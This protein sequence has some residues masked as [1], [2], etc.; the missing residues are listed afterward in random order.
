[1]IT[2]FHRN[3]K[4]KTR[5][6]KPIWIYGSKI[7][8]VFMRNVSLWEELASKPAGNE[9]VL[10]TQ[11]WACS[12]ATE[13]LQPFRLLTDKRFLSSSFCHPQSNSC[14]HCLPM[15]TRMSNHF[16]STLPFQFLKGISTERNT[17]T[18]KPKQPLFYLNQITDHAGWKWKTLG[19]S[20]E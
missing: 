18:K 10:V 7:M 15:L 14:T 2:L 12:H 13:T 1:M 16:C 5:R 3:F 4:I 6:S 20:E 19:W 11:R 8:L 9:K 17:E